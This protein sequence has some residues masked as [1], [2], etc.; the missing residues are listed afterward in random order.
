MSVISLAMVM[1]VIDV[2][3]NEAEKKV[4][5]KTSPENDRFV[6][7]GFAMFR[8]GLKQAIKEFELDK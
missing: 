7:I 8:A 4:L 5:N 6:R 3:I 1:P 2:L